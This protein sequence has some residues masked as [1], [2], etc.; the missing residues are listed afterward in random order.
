[1][2]ES[3]TRA[4]LLLNSLPV[5]EA[6]KMIDVGIGEA[7]ATDVVTAATGTGGLHLTATDL[8][9]DLDMIE[10]ELT[11]PVEEVG[12]T[13]GVGDVIDPRG[14]IG[15]VHQV[16][17][18]V[19]VEEEGTEAPLHSVEEVVMVVGR[20]VVPVLQGANT[21]RPGAL[22]DVVGMTIVTAVGDMTQ[23]PVVASALTTTVMLQGVH[24]APKGMFTVVD[25]TIE[26]TALSLLEIRKHE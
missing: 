24:A 19:A 17:T 11:T 8:I 18:E 4:F 15:L 22:Q 5:R 20:V 7:Q 9:E 2:V 14:L 16:D 12:T 1:M 10:T 25:A 21:G 23:D 3:L 6:T 26:V 13:L